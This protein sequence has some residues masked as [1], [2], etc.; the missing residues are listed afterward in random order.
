[1]GRLQ[2]C[3]V[4]ELGKILQW[5]YARHDFWLESRLV[6]FRN[7]LSVSVHRVV[8]QIA[9]IVFI[10]WVE[11]GSIAGRG[12][13]LDYWSYA[14]AKGEEYPYKLVHSDHAITLEELQACAAHQGTEIRYGDIL[15]VRCGYWY[16]Y[17]RLSHEERV[18]WCDGKSMTH[19]GVL[20]SREM[21]KWLWDSGI[22]AC[23]GDALGWEAMPPKPG[24]GLD[25][26]H[27]LHEVMLAGWGMPIGKSD[28][29]FTCL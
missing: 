1:M 2:T 5:K 26:D 29:P 23:A 25:N 11:A 13:L 16:T 12:V 10:A 4:H 15:I 28:I 9:N 18:D 22:V 20:P 7:T 19:V 8:K 17:N 24:R 27:I 3:F 6:R 14:Q 21:A